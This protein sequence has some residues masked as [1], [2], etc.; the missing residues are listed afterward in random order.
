MITRIDVDGFKSLVDVGIDVPPFLALIGPNGSGKSNLLEALRFVADTVDD[1]FDA[2]AGT[3]PRGHGPQ[4][5]HH[6]GAGPVT[7][8]RVT[9][10]M[11]VASEVGPLPVR[12][13]VVGRL[14]DDFAVMDEASRLWV[15]NL[16]QREWMDRLGVAPQLRKAISDA[17]DAFL[18]QGGS[19]SVELRSDGRPDPGELV[20]LVRKECSTW[21]A[22]ALDPRTMRAPAQRVGKAH[23]FVNLRPDG[24]NLAEVLDNLEGRR[25]LGDLNLDLGALIPGAESVVALFDARREEYDFDLVLV[26]DGPT[27]PPLLS[28][29]TLRVLGT[30]AA[31]Y[32]GSTGGT[33]VIEEI[34][35]GLHPTRLAELLRRL[36]R[37]VSDL[38]RERADR[39][40]R[41]LVVTTHSPVLMSALRER[42]DGSLILLDPAIHYG[43]EPGSRST[44]TWARPVREQATGDDPGVCATPYEVRRLLDT[45]TGGTG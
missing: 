23:E 36:L 18:A 34:E 42:V 12:V 15:D 30:L 22:L 33:L 9:V 3:H 13:R 10:G 24:A 40:L 37:D 38:S 29:G 6:T 11:L 14:V 7:S 4:L 27:I 17:R 32:A 16:E 45:V 20:S 5:F 43:P 28:D 26:G 21:P 25:L 41:Q 2:A 1:G 31:S 35:N 44:I 8:F 39:P 19:T